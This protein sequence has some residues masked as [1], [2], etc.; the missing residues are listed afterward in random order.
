MRIYFNDGTYVDSVSDMKEP[1]LF[2]SLLKSKL[3]QDMV[4]MYHDVLSDILYE[5]GE[6][7]SDTLDSV[8]YI[9]QESKKMLDVF[10]TAKTISRKEIMSALEKIHGEAD[11]LYDEIKFR[12]ED[13]ERGAN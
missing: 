13:L 6:K 2:E 5:H 1:E 9:M 10:Q 7:L 3:G 4:T 8:A 11:H 12:A